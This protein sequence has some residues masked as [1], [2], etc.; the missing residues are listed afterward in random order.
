MESFAFFAVPEVNETKITTEY[1]FNRGHFGIYSKHESDN[2]EKSLVQVFLQIPADLCF[3][4][5]RH[6][7][8]FLKHYLSFAIFKPLRVPFRRS[9][10]SALNFE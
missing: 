1:A 3:Q 6:I 10:N 8:T 2:D 9:F 4:R 5:E 7:C